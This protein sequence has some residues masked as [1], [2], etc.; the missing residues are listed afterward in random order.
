[1]KSA[2]VF[3]V[4]EVFMKADRH[5]SL[6]G[7][8]REIGYK[9]KGFAGYDL[10][11]GLISNRSFISAVA[12]RDLMAKYRGAFIGILWMVGTPAALV[13]AYGYMIVGVFNVRS[14]GHS[15]A[16]TFVTLW[17]C[18][19][20]WQFFSEAVGRSASIVSD[21]ASLVKRS[22][23]PLTALPPA[24]VMTSL[25]GLGVSL[26]LGLLA[27]LIFVGTPSTSWL[28]LLSVFPALSFIT[29]ASVYFVAT[30]GAFSKDIRY[31]LPLGM[32]VCMLMS[33]V[34]YSSERVPP[35]LRFLSE[36]NPIAPIFETVR[37]VTANGQ[38]QWVPLA[39]TTCVSLLA[40]IVSFAFYRS[41]SVEFA[42]VL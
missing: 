10:F 24:V 14:E 12:R 1:M 28:L 41:K 32:T 9:S 22:P 25:M 30:V 7:T 40:A 23:F 17:L 2:I 39:V 6:P 13:L 37:A 4:L 26:F 38:P 15:T 11:A 36:F 33:P 19:S 35:S 5:I 16:A 8:R 29:L 34:L 31:I 20:L 27:Q 3:F 42:D 21:N 18:V